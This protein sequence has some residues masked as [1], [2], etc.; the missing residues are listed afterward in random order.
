MV[1]FSV[2]ATRADKVIDVRHTCAV[3]R[4]AR[5]PARAGALHGRMRILFCDSAAPGCAPVEAETLPRR[6]RCHIRHNPTPAHRQPPTGIGPP[7]R[8]PL[9]CH[10][11]TQIAERTGLPPTTSRWPCSAATDDDRHQFMIPCRFRLRDYACVGEK[12]SMV[13]SQTPS[14]PEVVSSITQRLS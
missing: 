9:T 2:E 10:T 6:L 1:T 7:S 11:R 12:V 8:R 4:P 5:I 14:K 13:W 3:A